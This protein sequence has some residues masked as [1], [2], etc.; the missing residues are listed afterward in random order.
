[1][2]LKALR[3]AEH[4]D[5][6]GEALD[7]IAELVTAEY[8][9]GTGDPVGKALRHELHKVGRLNEPKKRAA[10][11]VLGEQAKAIQTIAET[12]VFDHAGGMGFSVAEGKLRLARGIY[13]VM[14]TKAPSGLF[15]PFEVNGKQKAFWDSMNPDYGV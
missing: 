8:P 1:M 6:Q 14:F 9:K 4:H 10:Y 13:D 11:T 3:E 5:P 12:M 15:E 2:S 7:A